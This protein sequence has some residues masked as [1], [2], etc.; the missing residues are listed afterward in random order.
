MIRH[1]CI[2]TVLLVAS[3]LLA[4]PAPAEP[5]EV[6]AA[7][8][9][10]VELWSSRDLDRVDTLFLDDGRLTYLSSEKEGL[11][12]GLDAVREHHRGFGF[13]PG[14]AEA[15]AELWI[16][17]PVVTDLGSSLVVTAL[18]LFGDRDTAAEAQRGPM[19]VVY[20]R[21]PDGLRIAHMHF[22]N[23]PSAEPGA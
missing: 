17:D 13:A 12:Q 6:D 2:L 7:L 3:A 23:Y 16:E 9:T 10:W 15:T 5:S 22:A 18:W 21:T 1:R 11:I 14:G 8:A 19:T 20:L 4:H